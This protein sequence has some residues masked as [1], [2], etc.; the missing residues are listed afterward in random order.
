RLD[1][2]KEGLRNLADPRRLPER[3]A[4]RL[5]SSLPAV[6]WLA[7]G[8]HGNETSSTDAGLFT[9]YHLT[10]AQNDTLAERVL[11]DSVVIIDPLQNP[12]GRDRFIHYYRQTRGRWPD[13]DP[14]AA[15]H[16][17]TW[18]S[19]R[20][21]HYLFDMNRDWFA[22]TQPE[23]Q[24]RVKAFLE[25]FPQ[26][27]VD[28]HEMGFNSTYYFPPPAL[29][30]NPDLADSQIEWLRK[31][32]QDH[33]KWF[34]RMQFDYFTRE[35]FD[36]F[37]PGYG[38]GWP[39]FQGSIAMTFEQASADGLVVRRQ[40]ET[41]LHY[42]EA[43]QHH[44]ISSLA[45]AQTAADNRESLLR[46][47][48][49][50]RLSAIEEGAKAK[51]K[52]YIIPVGRDPN[53]ARKLVS[54]LMQQGIEVK[55]AKAPFTNSKVRDYYN[56]GLQSQRFSAGTFIVSLAQPAK[57]LAN[58][59][60]VKHA[61]MEEEFIQEQLRRYKKRLGDQIYDI[62]AWSLPLLYDVDCYRAEEVSQ[63]EF[64]VLEDRPTAPGGV[65][66]D[67]G[68]VAYL[69][70]WG[71]NSAGKALSALLREGVRVYCADK[72]FNLNKIEFPA[73]SLIVKV[74][75]NPDDLHERLSK[76]AA[77]VGVDVYPTSISWVE[78]G[79]SLG[80]SQVL[81]VK[82]PSLALAYHLPTS[83]Y[84]VGTTRYLL[85]QVYRYPVTII[86]TRQL[87]RADLSKYNVLILPDASDSF[88][89]Y[90]D[91]LG[92]EGAQQI[93][94][95]VK[96][97]GTLVAI[98]NATQWLTGEKVG[99]LDTSREFRGGKPE[100][101]VSKPDSEG[102]SAETSEPSRGLSQSFDLDK[103]IQ[104]EKELPA[105]TP[106]AI[107]RVSLDTEHWLAFGY[108]GDTQVL[109]KSRNI[110]TPIKLDKGRNVGLYMQ[111]DKILLSGFTWQDAQKQ[112]AQKAYLMHQTHGRGHVVAFAEDPNYRAFCDG[113][114]LLFLNAVFFGPAH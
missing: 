74:R 28:L 1:K 37:Y 44:F 109:V 72:A 8:I 98:G 108:D 106:G 36:A 56:E 24:G 47:F 101:G 31:L 21:N 51:V 112:M 83:P 55:Q 27:F 32:G 33:A 79:I 81:Y 12:D 48:Y 86:H 107:M 39:M 22:L 99:L 57:N 63:G 90:Q 110:F 89:G 16:S 69:I 29:P 9:A 103:A 113:L 30:L 53:R 26:V 18:P 94:E 13:P 61:Q 87:R 77:A 15:E 11:R 104:P 75:D 58:T 68:S 88:G 14:Q 100:K 45:T 23:T 80:S 20:M 95:W 60:L 67:K 96:G 71:T 93:K 97:G 62:T 46:Y 49:D 91:A 59:L 65:H 73:G 6:I 4:H 84:S 7:Y 76:V 82:K 70:P 40:D 102:E 2:I 92:E 43:I 111:E 52:E 64:K 17:E 3:Q 85:E 19:G 35:V 41:L 34:D 105:N 38:D 10:A 78:K 54:L 114:N 50:Y 25:W 5:I 66:G 42:R